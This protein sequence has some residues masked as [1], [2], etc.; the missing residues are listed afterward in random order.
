MS[1]TIGHVEVL[2]EDPAPLRDFYA[3]VFGWKVGPVETDDPEQME[4]SMVS[5]EDRPGAT[6]AG[7]GRRLPGFLP[8]TFYVQVEDLEA[9]LSSIAEHG[10]RTVTPPKPVGPATKIARFADPAGNVIGLVGG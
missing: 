3:A 10:G 2:S 1:G 7:I 9:A 4:Y 8:V 6:T 5:L